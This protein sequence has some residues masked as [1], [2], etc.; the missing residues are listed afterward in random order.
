MTDE[1]RPTEVRD[2]YWIRVDAP[3][4]LG[5]EGEEVVTGKWM[6]FVWSKNVDE[7]WSKIRDAT[8]EGRL[9][10]AAKVATMQPNSNAFNPDLKLICV[11]TE[12]WRDVV[13]VLRVRKELFRMGFDRTLT[14]KTDAATYRG[15]YAASGDSVAMY[16]GKGTEKVLEPLLG[17]YE[18]KS[19]RSR[20]LAYMRLHS[21]EVHR[22]AKKHEVVID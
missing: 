11:Y 8:V 7:I 16:R 20:V 1:R 12:D 21:E 9:G 15:E 3:N 4:Y 18:L 2:D 22:I 19:E 13:D 14:Y 17:D 5:P 10:I 6:I